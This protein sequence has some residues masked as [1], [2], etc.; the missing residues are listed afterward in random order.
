MGKHLGGLGAL[1]QSRGVEGIDT[2]GLREL[3]NECRPIE[4]GCGTNFVI[5]LMLICHKLSVCLTASRSSV[6]SLDS[7]KSPPWKT[8]YSSIAAPLQDLLDVAFAIPPLAEKWKDAKFDGTQVIAGLGGRPV[9]QS[10]MSD[11]DMADLLSQLLNIY[12]LLQKWY[13][14]FIRSNQEYMRIGSQPATWKN[15]RFDP[16]E[17][18]K[19][20]LFS[21]SYTFSHFQ[22][23]LASVY[24]DGIR[25]QL[26]KNIEEIFSE[27]AVR[28]DSSHGA[29]MVGMNTPYNEALA[30]LQGEDLII[31][32]TRV[33]E[34][35]EYFMDSDKKLI[36]PTRFMFAFH[37]SF[38]ALCRL[39]KTSVRGTYRRQ[40]RWCQLISEKYEEAQ[41]ASLT[42][43]DIGKIVT[44]LLEMLASDHLG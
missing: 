22:I 34:C 32:V 37:V 21:T 8:H 42:S 40:I 7:W 35:A 4:V 33:L 3:Y 24:F 20:K 2:F 12:R 1:F 17:T 11:K 15:S 31:S 27:L 25:I 13:E 29:N 38:S 10:S 44:T 5:P 14:D 18:V 16:E 41:L 30:L 23:A 19:G 6:F 28:V 36:G 9:P 39:S 43:L 26:L